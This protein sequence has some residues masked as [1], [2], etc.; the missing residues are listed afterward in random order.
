[1]HNFHTIEVEA[2]LRRLDWERTAATDA[3]ASLASDGT[4]AWSR[5]K[6]LRLSLAWFQP[7]PAPRESI[8]NSLPARG[9]W[10]ATS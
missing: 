1:M 9:V 7:L 5:L 4:N 3:R 6:L 2:E 8:T 10:P